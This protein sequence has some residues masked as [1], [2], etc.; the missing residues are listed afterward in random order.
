M[1]HTNLL[2]IFIFLVATASAQPKVASITLSGAGPALAYSYDVSDGTKATDG[3]KL[4]SDFN[5]KKDRGKMVFINNTTND[6]YIQFYYKK[7]GKEHLVSPRT[8]LKKNDGTNDGTYIVNIEKKGSADIVNDGINIAYIGFRIF[9]AP[10]EGRNIVDG[11][12][13]LKDK[14]DKGAGITINT[15]FSKQ[16]FDNIASVKSYLNDK[17]E[18]HRNNFENLVIVDNVIHIFLD[19][20][21]QPLLTDYPTTARSGDKF[22]FHIF[23]RKKYTFSYVGTGVYVPTPIAEELD[24]KSTDAA[25][26]S[27]TLEEDNSLIEYPSQIFGPFTGSFQIQMLRADMTT[28]DDPQ[29]I[30]NRT[31]KL[32][33]VSRVSLNTGVVSSFLKGPENISIY[34]KANGD[35]TLVADFP[36]VR[37][38]VTVMLTFHFKP[39]NLDIKPRDFGWERLGFTVG[40][41]ISSATIADNYFFGLN[42]EL[43]NG[44]FVNCGSHLGKV[45]YVVGKDNFVFGEEKF[46]GTLLTK[47]KWA[48]GPY[49]SVSIDAGLFAKAFKN[50]S[51]SAK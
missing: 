42:Y 26:Q 11:F 9:D 41:N 19:E 7:K 29:S 25:I 14:P 33:K 12:A 28:E 48:F 47:E 43:A 45:K 4:T 50:I 30:L 51:S 8:K 38:I 1:K 44:L 15:K 17:Y 2:T 37:A 40:T 46:S 20:N 24:K 32:L 5:Y 3:T 13:P 10:V 23:S 36:S 35:S 16:Q 49:I 6:Y 34:Q 39:R 22:Q 27:G 31:I 21:G 18:E